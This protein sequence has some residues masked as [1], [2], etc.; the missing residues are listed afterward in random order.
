MLV[1]DE[2]KKRKKSV[3]LQFFDFVEGLARSVLL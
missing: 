2:L 1:T 3:G